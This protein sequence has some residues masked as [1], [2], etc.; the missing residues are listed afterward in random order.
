ML[1]QLV[2][3]WTALLSGLQ[4]AGSSITSRFPS[5]RDSRWSARKC[6]VFMAPP[7]PPPL[8]PTV[9]RKAELMVDITEHITGLKGEKGC[10]GTRGPKG[11]PGVMGPEG[12]PGTQGYMGQ[13]GQKGEKGDRGWRG[14]Y[15]DIGTPGM[16]K[17]DKGMKGHRGP[18]G[19]TGERGTTGAPGEKGDPGLR[20]DAGRRGEQGPRGKPGGRGTMGLMGSRGPT[21]KLGR[22]GPAGLRG[23]TGEPGLPGQVYILPGLQGDAGNRGPPAKCNCSQVQ[24]PQRLLGRVPTIFIADGER[25]MRRLRGENVMVLR[26]DREALYIYTESQWINVLIQRTRQMFPSVSSMS[27]PDTDPTPFNTGWSALDQNLEPQLLSGQQ[28]RL[29]LGS[30]QSECV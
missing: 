28:F 2:L 5:G 3:G 30:F 7:P 1:T 10:R 9:K 18:S 13:P 22:P 20:G 29:L 19:E 25:Q 26:T 24:S 17:G 16:I 11:Q 21:G 27:T 14:L 23:R 6:E 8:F 4:P 12:E 15:G